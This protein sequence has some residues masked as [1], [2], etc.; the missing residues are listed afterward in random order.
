[1]DNKHTSG[2]WMTDGSE[3]YNQ[4]NTIAAINYRSKGIAEEEAEANAKIIA[5][6]PDMLEALNRLL[7]H[8]EIRNIDLP[9]RV[10]EQAQNAINKATL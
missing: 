9:E 4:Y 8:I 2:E 6:A 10:L 5:A 7:N 3:I 1:M